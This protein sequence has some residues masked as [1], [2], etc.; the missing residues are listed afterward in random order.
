MDFIISNLSII[1]VLVIYAFILSLL[2]IFI[3]IPLL[4]Q[5]I[6]KG[7][8]SLGIFLLVMFTGVYRRKWTVYKKLLL[9]RSDLAILGF[10]FLIP[11][12]VHRLSLALMA[13]K[14][15]DS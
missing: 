15:L 3:E 5:V 14:R 12:D 10:I 13:I 9:V 8:L 2:V 1:L 4:S 6:D 7:H 11:Y